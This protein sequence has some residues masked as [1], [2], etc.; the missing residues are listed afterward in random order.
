MGDVLIMNDFT[1]EELEFICNA[2]FY[3][4]KDN[5]F[6][7][8]VNKLQSMIDDYCEPKQIDGFTKDI[9]DYTG[10]THKWETLEIRYPG[11]PTLICLKCRALHFIRK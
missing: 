3:Y 4:D 2:V 11:M 9:G 1:K 10:Y 5:S 8:F 7:L 6:G